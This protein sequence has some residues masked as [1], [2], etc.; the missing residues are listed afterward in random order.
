M[1]APAGL[2]SDK[3]ASSGL[4]SFAWA[5]ETGCFYSLKKFEEP[6]I[7]VGMK[8]LFLSLAAL[9]LFILP[10]SAQKRMVRVAY[11]PQR[12]FQDHDVMTG[13]YSGYAYEYLLAIKQYAGWD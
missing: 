7:M 6:C 5:P 2:E 13:R 12:G 1:P 11:Y 8:R 4:G 3:V 10:M 9:F